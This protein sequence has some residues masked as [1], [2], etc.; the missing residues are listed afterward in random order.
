FL[1][2]LL[3]SEVYASTFDV[4]SVF[5]SCLLGS[6]AVIKLE[7]GCELFLSCLLGSEVETLFDFGLFLKSLSHFPIK[8]PFF[9]PITI[10][11]I[12]Q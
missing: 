2:C 6:E 7:F 8:N 12:N 10:L 4:I 11:F 9:S 3:G 5:L 1:S